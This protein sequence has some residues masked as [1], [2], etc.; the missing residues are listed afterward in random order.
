[1]LQLRVHCRVNAVTYVFSPTQVR[2]GDVLSST[3]Q[4]ATS[5]IS[6]PEGDGAASFERSPTRM[7]GLGT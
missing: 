3:E 7:F 2:S 1:M 6:L 5:G 4:A